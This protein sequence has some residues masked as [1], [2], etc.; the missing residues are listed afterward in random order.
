[1][2]KTVKEL[3]DKAKNSFEDFFRSRNIKVIAG[4]RKPIRI[5]TDIY[6]PVPDVA[7]GPFNSSDNLD[8]VENCKRIYDELVNF[9]TNLI[10]QSKKA[11]KNNLRNYTEINLDVRGLS[12]E[13]FKTQNCSNPNSRCFIAVEIE[14]TNTLKHILGSAINAIA[15]GR[16]ALLVGFNPDRTFRFLRAL[17]YLDFANKAGKLQIGIKNAFVLSKEQFEDILDSLNR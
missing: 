7:V 3:Q 4:I 12:T 2:V 1:V 10:N 8:D 17:A 13:N 6:S 9:S 15:L 5:S 14:N 16:I 11:F